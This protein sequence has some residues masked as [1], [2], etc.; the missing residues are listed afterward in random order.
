MTLIEE[1]SGYLTITAMK[2]IVIIRNNTVVP[3]SIE[4]R[5]G[6]CVV[7]FLGQFL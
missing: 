6:S 3:P 4:T 1:V 5:S 2:Q 7:L